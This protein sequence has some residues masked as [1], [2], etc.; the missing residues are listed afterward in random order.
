MAESTQRESQSGEQA[1]KVP[2]EVFRFLG[3]A[4]LRAQESRD[5]EEVREAKGV[6]HR[7]KRKVQFEEVREL[8]ELLAVRL[9]VRKVPLQAVF[10]RVD[11]ASYRGTIDIEKMKQ[12][13]SEPPL[14][15][16]DRKHVELLSRYIVEDNRSDWQE[17]S[18]LTDSSES[19]VVKSI[20]RHL[21]CNYHLPSDEEEQATFARVASL[22]EAGRQKI[23]VGL[24][25]QRQIYG[26]ECTMQQFAEVLRKNE[27]VLTQ[28]ELD[29]VVAKLYRVEGLRNTVAFTELLQVFLNTESL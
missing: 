16:A 11:S 17:E 22:L 3:I 26:D 25:H 5:R 12:I 9:R 10:D 6:E 13:L 23:Q 18:A 7:R 27:V 19:T 1:N 2:G 21:L 4:S 28:E 20:L 24:L 29:Y 8:G 15:V 14:S